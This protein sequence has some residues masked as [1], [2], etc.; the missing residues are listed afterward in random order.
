MSPPAAPVAL[1]ADGHNLLFTCYCGM[2]DR[3]RSAGGVPIH[4]TYGFIAVLLK[5]IRRFEPRVIVVCFDAEEQS[6]RTSIDSSYKSNRPAEDPAAFS[7]L[8]D[9][10]RGLEYLNVPWLEIP[11]V[12][13]DDV[14]GT[15]ARRLAE[16]HRVYIA[17]T[18]HD[19]YQLIDERTY[20]FPPTRG[21]DTEYGPEEIVAK[22]GVRPE[23]FVDWKVL[24]GDPSDN[25][26]GVSGIG[27]KT[28]SMLL[29]AFGDI[30]GILAN[31]GSLRARTAEALVESQERIE[32]NRQLITIKTDVEAPLL[33]G[34]FSFSPRG[35]ARSLSV[36]TI[37]RG[38]GLMA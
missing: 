18:D 35:D 7:Q 14:M 1:V 26:R 11:G 24:V 33:E 31:L 37:M 27:R 28:A 15:L 21:T 4:G 34:D 17:S 20:V 10:K 16:S 6:F 5:M 38:L 13:A 36:R 22:Y 12:E 3:I 25:I 8:V 23:Q 2:P 29:N 19:M 32:V 9:V 30:P